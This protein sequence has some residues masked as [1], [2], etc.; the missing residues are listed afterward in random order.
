MFTGKQNVM[1]SSRQKT[2]LDVTRILKVAERGQDA[3]F[4]YLNQETIRENFFGAPQ[5]LFGAP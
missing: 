3:C 4:F 5:M 1:N 2:A